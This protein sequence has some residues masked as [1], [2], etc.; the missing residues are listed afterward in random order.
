MIKVLQEK[1]EHDKTALRGDYEALIQQ[2]R[3]EY[4]GQKNEMRE[5]QR[6]LEV[7]LAIRQKE[8]KEMKADFEGKVARMSDEIAK[9]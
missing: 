6:K 1:H 5:Q 8:Y 3:E 2:I 9:L 4:Q 7:E